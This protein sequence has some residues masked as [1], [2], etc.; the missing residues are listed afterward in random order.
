MK[1]PAEAG[2]MTAWEW[3]VELA[4]HV[5]SLRF[6]RNSQIVPT[7]Y[8]PSEKPKSGIY[9]LVQMW[10]KCNC[11]TTTIRQLAPT[12][13]SARPTQL[14]VAPRHRSCHPPAWPRGA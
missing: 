14:A 2:L 7:L 10:L 9:R 11:N 6:K 13:G 4:Q 8:L 12:N 3:L 5:L 1:N